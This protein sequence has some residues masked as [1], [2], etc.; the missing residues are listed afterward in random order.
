MTN[1]IMK[2][3]FSDGDTILIE[4][5]LRSGQCVTFD[6]NVV[7]RGDVNAGAEIVA[8]GH[9]LVFGALRGMV[10][11]GACGMDYASVLALSLLP[12]QLRIAGH[13]TCPPQGYYEHAGHKPE[14]ARLADGKVVIEE[15][16]A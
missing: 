8:S 12:T 16:L 13:I 2:Q 10:H 6:G 1:P 14:I 15:F 5:P 3:L 9:L 7:V 11:G 4:G